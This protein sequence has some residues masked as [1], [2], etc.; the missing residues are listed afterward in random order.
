MLYH[1]KYLYKQM[2]IDP[3]I[4]EQSMNQSVIETQGQ[5]VR[6]LAELVK[7][8]R[9]R[10]QEE[11]VPKENHDPIKSLAN[12]RKF[13]QNRQKDLLNWFVLRVQQKYDAFQNA[14]L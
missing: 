2:G 3:D 7:D 4:Q 11:E 6:D 1:Q 10:I 14:K 13:Y 9:M 8:Q 5:K 12:M